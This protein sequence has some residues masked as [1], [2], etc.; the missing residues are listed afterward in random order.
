M[1]NPRWAVVPVAG[2]G[3]RLLPASAVVPK[4]LL[5]VGLR[6]MLHWT[7]QEIIEAGLERVILV[8]GPEQGLIGDYLQAADRASREGRTDDLGRLGS[9]LRR[10]DVHVVVQPVACGVGDAFVRCREITGQEPFAVLLPDNWF[11][12]AV[13]AIGQVIDTFQR[14]RQPTLGLTAVPPEESHLFGN[15]GGVRLQRVRDRSYQILALQDKKPGTFQ[16]SRQEVLRGCGRYVLTPEFYDALTA[17]GPPDQ[18][19]WDDVPAFQR[20][21]AQGRL[22]GHLIQGRHYDVG[23]PPGYLAAAA[24][25][26]GGSGKD[27]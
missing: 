16:A 2:S 5:P 11:A 18:G 9:A 21:I 6:P 15:V 8:R 25:L 13:P 4:A 22:A 23:L 27:T 24:W 10:I 3:T 12:S 14:L 7:L 26:A 17:T 1:A 19:E 20:L